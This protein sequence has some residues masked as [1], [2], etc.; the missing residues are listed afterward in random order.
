MRSGAVVLLAGRKR[1]IGIC[2][3][4]VL[5]SGALFFLRGVQ[6]L[7]HAGNA[8]GTG[9]ATELPLPLVRCWVSC[10]GSPSVFITL[11]PCGQPDHLK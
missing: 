8:G 5:G 1:H 9:V 3:N 11:G 10:R 2:A 7:P 4:H 6:L